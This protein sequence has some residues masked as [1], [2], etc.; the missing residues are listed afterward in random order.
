[1]AGAVEFVVS[2]VRR[3]RSRFSL[4]VESREDGALNRGIIPQPLPPRALGTTRRARPRVAVVAAT[5]PIVEPRRSRR[6]AAAAHREGQEPCAE[7][8]EEPNDGHALLED[9][10]G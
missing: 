2:E 9:R 6:L 1:M 3:S 10:G 5:A 8:D 7:R 4:V